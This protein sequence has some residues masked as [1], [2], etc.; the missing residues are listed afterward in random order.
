MTIQ[1][2]QLLRV[3]NNQQHR[4]SHMHCATQCKVVQLQH[5]PD[6]ALISPQYCNSLTDSQFINGKATVAEAA[7]AA[8]LQLLLLLSLNLAASAHHA[9]PVLLS[10][11]R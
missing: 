6:A 7:L 4:S 10:I 1:H 11:S 3:N 5:H 9:P 2:H 8:A